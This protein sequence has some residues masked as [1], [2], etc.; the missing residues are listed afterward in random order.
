MQLFNQLKLVGK[1]S[2]S[3]SLTK[4][5]FPNIVGQAPFQSLK[6]NAKFREET[7]GKTILEN[8]QS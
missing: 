8:P 6:K 7:L 2:V 5:H 3:S 4:I 1:M